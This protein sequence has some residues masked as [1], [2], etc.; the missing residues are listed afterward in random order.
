MVTALHNTMMEARYRGAV[1]GALILQAIKGEPYVF[2]PGAEGAVART[3][4]R[5]GFQPIFTQSR[6]L[7]LRPLGA[8]AA[9]LATRTGFRLPN[10]R[11]RDAARRS[12]GALMPRTAEELAGIVALINRAHQGDLRPHWTVAGMY[13]RFFHPE[14]PFSALWI[15]GSLDA[16]KSF[17]IV[18][19]G[20][21]HGVAFARV[22]CSAGIDGTLHA[23]VLEKAAKGAY[24]IGAHLIQFSSDDDSMPELPRWKRVRN[25]PEASLF[26]RVPTGLPVRFCPG[27]GDYGLE[28]LITSS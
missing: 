10:F 6:I 26:Q 28:S 23:Q 19:L 27:A 21:R 18:S 20:R 16:P 2:V 12:S 22:L 14:G 9:I 1:G 5:L 24:A 4:R 15:E 7:L 8:A 11:V 13:W 17:A 25:A 3:L